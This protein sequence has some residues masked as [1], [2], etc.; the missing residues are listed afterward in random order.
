MVLPITGVTANIL[1]EYNFFAWST[2]V[3]YLIIQGILQT[4]RQRLIIRD[5][6]AFANR[7][8]VGLRA[9]M[10]ATGIWMSRYSPFR[11]REQM[12]LKVKALRPEHNFSRP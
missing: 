12:S 10:S 6:I 11:D 8:P 3:A 5:A 7:L 4:F 2:H 1:I 9:F